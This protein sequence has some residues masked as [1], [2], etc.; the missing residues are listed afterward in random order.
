MKF[1]QMAEL[2]E[3]L[4]PFLD[5]CSVSRLPEVHPLTAEILEG[6]GSWRK[7]MLRSSFGGARCG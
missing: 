6:A 5:A 1:W 2:V 7:L 3:S 4:L